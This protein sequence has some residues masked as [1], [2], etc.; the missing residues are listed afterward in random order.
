[1]IHQP[2][3]RNCAI[4]RPFGTAFLVAH[5]QTITGIHSEIRAMI[6]LRKIKH[7]YNFA[8]LQGDLFGLVSENWFGT[9]RLVCWLLIAAMKDFFFQDK[10]LLRS[11]LCEKSRQRRPVVSSNIC[12]FPGRSEISLERWTS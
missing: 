4:L 3:S 2:I 8:R 12:T 1:M 5:S 11:C 7:S 6:G 10:G 9:V